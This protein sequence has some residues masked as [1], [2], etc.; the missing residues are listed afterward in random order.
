MP[1][2]VAEETCLLAGGH[3]QQLIYLAK[4]IAF[5]DITGV[6]DTDLNCLLRLA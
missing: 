1:G 5:Q 3:I 4:D 6:R 2:N